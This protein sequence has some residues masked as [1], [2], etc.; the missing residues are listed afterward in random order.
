MTKT[1]TGVEK[2]K[3]TIDKSRRV[4]RMAL[5]WAEAQGLVAKAPIPE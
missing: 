5:V 4:L 1:R 2:A 3:P